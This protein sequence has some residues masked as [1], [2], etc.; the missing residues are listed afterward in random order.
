M[1]DR[2]RRFC[3]NVVKGMPAGRAYEAAGYAARGG[4]ADSAGAKLLR[5]DKVA[6]YLAELRE[7]ASHKAGMERDDLVQY[8]VDVMKTPVGEITEMSVLCQEWRMSG[9]DVVVKMPAKLAAAKQLAE[10]MGWNKPI[11]VKHGVDDKLGDLI[12]RIREQ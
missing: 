2:Q 4:S 11:E 8:L 9:E 6:K 12:R 7:A 1:N 3:E 10:M 5:N